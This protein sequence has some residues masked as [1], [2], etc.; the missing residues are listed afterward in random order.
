MPNH[1]QVAGVVPRL[2]VVIMGCSAF[3]PEDDRQVDRI[4]RGEFRPTATE[5][6]IVPTARRK[7]FRRKRRQHTTLGLIEQADDGCPN[8]VSAPQRAGNPR[9]I[10]ELAVV[11]EQGCTARTSLRQPG[12]ESSVGRTGWGWSGDQGEVD[13]HVTRPAVKEICA[14]VSLSLDPPMHCPR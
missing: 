5:A 4:H 1:V 7:S 14:R 3:L 12:V 6:T 8:E 11:G 10:V 2:T 9:H 13:M